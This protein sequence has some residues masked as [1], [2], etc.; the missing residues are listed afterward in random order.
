MII[1]IKDLTF[2]YR[3]VFYDNENIESEGIELERRTV[4]VRIGDSCVK[5]A[6][7]LCEEWDKTLEPSLLHVPPSYCK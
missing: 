1:G 3:T 7:G 6:D 5:K 2:Y 4:C